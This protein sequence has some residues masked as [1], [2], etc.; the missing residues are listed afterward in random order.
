[1]R[2]SWMW[3][4]FAAL[5]VIA[6]CIEYEEDLRLNADGSGVVYLRYAMNQFL[7][8]QMASQPDAGES[9][10]LP[11]TEKSIKAL[12]TGKPGLKLSGVK[13]WDE[14]EKRIVKFMV[15][16]DSLASLQKSGLGPFEGGFVFVRNADDTYVYERKMDNED[17]EDKNPDKEDEAGEAAKKPA[18]E[19]EVKK[20][21]EAEAEDKPEV[22][23]EQKP[24]TMPVSEGTM[25]EMGEAMAKGMMEGMSQA[26][27]SMMKQLPKF[28]FKLTLPKNIAETNASYHSG[29]YAEWKMEFS[30]EAMQSSNP[31]AGEV[32]TVKTSSV[33]PSSPLV[34]AVIAA[35]AA[36]VVVVLVIAV[37]R[38]RKRDSTTAAQFSQ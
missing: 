17:P 11:M 31:M 8:A 1:M 10:N 21:P 25:D 28:T 26:M 38:G 14:E 27:G 16:F 19:Q 34:Y 2:E 15:E 24:E 23:A 6:G 18:E 30:A 9:G 32:F 13:V 3:L 4:I 12:L 5:V 35:A 37:M 29:N 33:D 7:A 36:L 20:E 22:E